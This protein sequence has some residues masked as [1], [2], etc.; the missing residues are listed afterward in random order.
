[1]DSKVEENLPFTC[2]GSVTVIGSFEVLLSK[3]RE[4]C[5]HNECGE[6]VPAPGRG[7]NMASRES[8]IMYIH[9]ESR[10]LSIRWLARVR[11]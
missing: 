2:N 8:Y 4:R 7:H 3:G 6:K 1:M 10:N 11:L 5:L 9:L